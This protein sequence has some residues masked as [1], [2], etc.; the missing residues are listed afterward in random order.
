MSIL[1]P[2]PHDC[3]HSHLHTLPPSSRLSLS[4]LSL[5][6]SLL[7]SFPPSVPPSLL[8]LRDALIDQLMGENVELKGKIS[9]LEKQHQADQE[10]QMRLEAEI[11]EYKDIAQ[12]TSNVSV[13]MNCVYVYSWGKYSVFFLVSSFSLPPFL[14]SFPLLYF[15]SS[16]SCTAA[17]K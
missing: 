5:P 15:R 14:L 4:S 6:P 10:R 16:L 8:S 7:P 12:Q 3:T 11:R 2:H 13:L 17:S 9:E 1:V